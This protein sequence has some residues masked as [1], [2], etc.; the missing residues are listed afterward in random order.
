MPRPES[1][2][3]DEWE[4][5]TKQGYTLYETSGRSDLV[6]PPFEDS[7]RFFRSQSPDALDLSD[8]NSDA[9]DIATHI[10]KEVKRQRTRPAG[11]T[12]VAWSNLGFD[13]RPE[14]ALVYCD[15]GTGAVN[16][17]WPSHAE[18][19]VTRLAT[20]LQPVHSE[21]CDLDQD[22]LMDVLV[23]DIGEF[24]A[25]DS[26]LGR[27]VWLRRRSDSEKFDKH[28][29]ID[30]LSRVADA[31]PGDF[32]GDGDLD[33]LVA[34][35]GWR[36][37][38]LTLLLVNEGIDEEGT[39]T[40]VRRDV[41]PRHG[42]VHVPPIDFD[43]DGDLDFIGLLS[44]EH[45][46]VE[47]FRNDGTGRFQPELLWGAPDPAYGSCGIELADLDGDGDQDI[48][49]ANGDSF[50]RGPKP[51]HSVQWLENTGTTPFVHHHIC[52][53]PGV[54][55]AIPGDFDADGDVDLVA[56]SLLPSAITEKHTELATTSILM[57]VNNGSG[58]F[59]PRRVAGPSHDHISVAR[60]DFN[61]DG[62]PDFAVG[63]FLRAAVGE[64]P[65]G[66]LDKPELILF[67]SK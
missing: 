54:M 19:G 12:H 56:V 9:S 52:N 66:L 10:G 7:L 63:N 47:L 67:E 51:H 38:G 26:D 48:V 29:L 61:A 44:Q 2:P 30:G 34:A 36:N 14:P 31:R 6:P 40:F 1:S 8:P 22:G 32:D 23:S 60:G 5:E 4:M 13:S 42:P 35:F 64:D 58:G 11:I 50:D 46:R 39:A 25:D 18:D 20:L 16:A 45:E 3:A 49:F 17:Y 15:I 41:D 43:G 57:L 37:S 33:V 21:P 65:T 28:V 24:N 53:M 62:K 27:V 55:S 59:V